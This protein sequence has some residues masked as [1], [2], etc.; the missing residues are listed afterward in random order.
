MKKLENGIVVL[1][2]VE[3]SSSS[4]PN[5][6]K[7]N[8]KKKIVKEES[9]NG[10]ITIYLDNIVLFDESWNVSI[11]F[12]PKGELKNIFISYRERGEFLSWEAWDERR[13]AE[14][15][16]YHIH[17]LKKILGTQKKFTWGEITA[18]R[19]VKDMIPKITIS[20]F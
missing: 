16:K 6:V 7:E 5:E 10:W 9:V 4:T 3:V 15:T 14:R 11:M 13:E 8:L 20:Y 2:G 17:F 1:S 19:N 12:S 18:G